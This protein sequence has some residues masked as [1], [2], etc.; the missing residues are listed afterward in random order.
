MSQLTEI[1]DPRFRRLVNSNARLDLL[2]TG[3]RWA[4]GPAYFPAGRY[5]VWSDIPNDRMLRFDETTETVGVFRSPAGYSNGNTVD[6]QGRLVTCEHGNRRVT[7]TEHDGTITVLADRYEGKRLNSPNDVV[8][9]SDGTIYFTD[10]AYGIDSDYEGHKADSEIGACHV[11]RI[12]PRSGAVTI[13]ANDFVRPNGLAFSA[14]ERTL[15]IADTGA[16]HVADGPRHI[17]TFAV[18]EEGGLSGGEVFATC[19]AGLFDG[20]RLDEDGRLWTSAG[21]GVHCYHPDGTLIGKVRVPE[22]VA[23]VVFG[24]PKRNRLYICATTS[25]YAV[26]TCV[27]GVKTF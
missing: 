1:L 6:R 21:D 5:L 25:L 16:T 14:D 26:L 19:T 27:N 15:Y 3:C 12:D 13:A 8:V 7:R 22:V 11:Y 23:N 2:H 10:P 20:F 4:E 18:S 9:R 17:R 24:G